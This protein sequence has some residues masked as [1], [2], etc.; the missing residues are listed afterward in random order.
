MSCPSWVSLHGIAQSFSELLKPLRHDK[1]AI[2]EGVLYSYWHI[3]NHALTSIY[4]PILLLLILAPNPF[5]I[6]FL[7]PS[8]DL[9]EFLFYTILLHSSCIILLFSLESFHS[10]CS[11]N[12]QVKL[13]PAWKKCLS[14]SAISSPKGCLTGRTES[15]Q[16]IGH[17]K[18]CWESPRAQ[19]G[20]Y[21]SPSYKP[22]LIRLTMHHRQDSLIMQ[23]RGKHHQMTY[24]KFTVQGTNW[25][26]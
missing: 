22:A 24:D 12:P 2:H 5:P 13:C 8:A 6:L 16:E 11:T 19:L 7:K 21:N 1:A 23:G 18:M 14:L 10:Y 15:N 25:F 4:S 9:P 3:F 20:V 26:L 17:P